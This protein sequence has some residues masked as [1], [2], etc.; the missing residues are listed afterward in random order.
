MNISPNQS[1][2]VPGEDSGLRALGGIAAFYRIPIDPNQLAKDLALGGQFAQEED[3][4]RAAMRVGLRARILRA[5]QPDRLAKLPAPAIMKLRTGTFVVFG[6]VN[7][8]GLCRIIHPVTREEQVLDVD[9]LY[10]CIDP[11]AVLVGRKLTGPG[12][13][14]RTFG[15][16]WF[17]PSIWRYRRPLAHVLVASL[18]IQV[19]A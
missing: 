17:L 10:G 15:F 14:P 13:N 12:I 9:A 4:V 3:L 1:T 2:F 8:E 11:L 16:Q 6:G 19:F 5:I 7:A 18:F